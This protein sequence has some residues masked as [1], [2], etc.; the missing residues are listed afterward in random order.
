MSLENGIWVMK[1]KDKFFDLFLITF[2]KN[3][4]E[5]T[6]GFAEHI[7]TQLA[8]TTSII[9]LVYFLSLITLA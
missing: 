9:R 6:A 8:A 7:T 4:G 1:L 5:W 2:E 3:W